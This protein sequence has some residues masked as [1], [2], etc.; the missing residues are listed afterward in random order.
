MET[1]SK[2]LLSFGIGLVAGAIAGVI[3]APSSGEETRDKLREITNDSIDYFLQK[4][5]EGLSVAREAFDEIQES[6]F[7]IIN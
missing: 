4:A 7:D 3:L 5:E 1:A 6:K 2:I